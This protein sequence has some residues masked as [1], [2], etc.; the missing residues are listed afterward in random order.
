M[1]VSFSWFGVRRSLSS[2][3]CRQ[4]AEQFGAE[5][6]FISAGK[7]LVDTSHPSVR[8]VNQLRREIGE[9]WKG[10]SLPFPEP[11]IRLI[12]QQEIDSI[13]G[14]MQTFRSRLR[15]AVGDLEANYYEIKQLARQ[16]LGTLYSDGDYP[17]SFSSEFE[18]AWE[19]P[20]VEPPDYLRRLQPEIFEQECSRIRSRFDEAVQLAEQAFVDELSGLVSHLGERLSGSDDGKP[21]I[22]R[23]TAI[24]NLNEFFS[25]FQRLN[26]H[27]NAQLDAL[28][29]QAQSLMSGVRPQ[30]L[31]D[32][33]PLRQQVAT[34]LASVQ[35][36]LDGLMVDRP[37]RR[38]LRG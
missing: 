35:S 29:N 9:Y 8:A 16:R 6:A 17:A 23:D 32:S 24:E 21:K 1:R 34:Q 20:N 5:K 31:R 36:V 10:V 27:S 25:R 12:R 38:I 37:R 13:S 14:Q 15:D 18:V 28:V 22:F 2:D 26:I 7:K 33:G 19:F 11:G 30:Q 4:A 3:Q